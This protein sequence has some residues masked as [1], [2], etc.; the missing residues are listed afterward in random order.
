MNLKTLPLMFL[1]GVLVFILTFWALKHW[2]SVP[3][4]QAI[5]LWLMLVSWWY[6]LRKVPMNRNV[7]VGFY[8]G[9]ALV[10]SVCAV[11]IAYAL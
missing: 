7:H 5:S 8:V 2:L 9:A 6:F 11:L 4:T 10:V 1:T 3:Q